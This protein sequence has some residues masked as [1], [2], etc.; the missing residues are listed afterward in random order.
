MAEQSGMIR[1]VRAILELDEKQ[2]YDLLKAALAGEV[3]SCLLKLAME[4]P[5]ERKE[6]LAML[7]ESMKEEPGEYPKS[8]EN[9]GEIGIGG[10]RHLRVPFERPVDFSTGGKTARGVSLDL[11]AGGL[12]L[13][14][15]GGLSLT[16]GQQLLVTFYPPGVDEA[17]DATCEVLR[18][19]ETGVAVKFVG[20]SS[21]ELAVS[22]GRITEKN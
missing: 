8:L 11:S 21:P 20:E 5:D 13:A 15:S 2:Q 3:T 6:R 14:T 16:V 18:I 17:V 9:P 7:A 22:I 12:F 10:R 1:L 4:M 19:T